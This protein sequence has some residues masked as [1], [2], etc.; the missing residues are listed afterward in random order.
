MAIDRAIQRKG[1]LVVLLTRLVMMLPYPGLNYSLGLTSVSLRDYV[2]GTNIG[3]LP[4]FF[5]FVYLGTTV[6]DITALINGDVSLEGREMLIGM[7]A[8]FVVICLVLLIVRVAGKI[9]KEELVA[10]RE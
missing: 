7:T 2:L 1:F 5:L 10:A 8:L 9:L 3:G 6:S 4:A